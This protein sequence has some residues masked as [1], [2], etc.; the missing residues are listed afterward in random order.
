MRSAV[1]MSLLM[2]VGFGAVMS[3]PLAWLWPYRHVVWKMHG[4]A[5]VLYVARLEG[6]LLGVFWWVKRRNERFGRALGKLEREM[7]S[8]R[9]IEP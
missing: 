4:T 7:V 6:L 9:L 2:M 8:G 3:R 1:F 5:I